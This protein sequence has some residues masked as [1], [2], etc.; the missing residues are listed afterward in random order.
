MTPI[1]LPREHRL[2]RR[3]D[4]RQVARR[5]RRV[6]APHLVVH[7]LD[8]PVGVADHNGQGG[9]G[10]T[11]VGFVVSKAVGAAVQRNLVRRRLRHAVAARLTGLPGVALVVRAK[12][13]AATA[14]FATLAGEL[15]DCLRRL[16]G[17]GGS[18]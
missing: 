11:R 4:F 15:D 3:S 18:P 9:A 13:A 16:P 12:P 6:A 8:V 2:R 1:V 5:G 7:A 17:P 14:S 10:P